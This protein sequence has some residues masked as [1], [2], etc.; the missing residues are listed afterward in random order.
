MPLIGRWWRR[1]GD[2]SRHR[3]WQGHGCSRRGKRRSGWASRGVSLPK[4]RPK[5]F[6]PVRAPMR[7]GCEGLGRQPSGCAPRMRRRRAEATP[8][9]AGDSPRFVGGR[10]ARGRGFGRTRLPACGRGR[11]QVIPLGRCTGHRHCP[12]CVWVGFAAPMVLGMLWDR[13]PRTPWPSSA[14]AGFL[15]P[16]LACATREVLC[17]VCVAA[18]C[19]TASGLLNLCQQLGSRT[20]L[21]MRYMPS[22]GSRTLPPPA[23][24]AHLP[25]GRFKHLTSTARRS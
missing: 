19:E 1:A 3:G 7:G 25:K 22:L 21:A 13:W 23:G 14:A 8:G 9:V 17:S 15:P 20:P 6:Y 5:P 18:V 11:A 2:G 12:R 10:G 24:G 4:R 16:S